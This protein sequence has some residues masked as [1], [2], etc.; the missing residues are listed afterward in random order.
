MAD[1]V[2]AALIGAGISL[3]ISGAMTGVA[4]LLR[5]Q[6]KTPN[7]SGTV[8]N[9]ISLPIT[10]EGTPIAYV[11]GTSKMSG[12]ITWPRSNETLVAHQVAVAGGVGGGK[13]DGGGGGSSTETQYE[14]SWAQSLCWGVVSRL[15]AIEVNDKRVWSGNIET[16]ESGFY[17][18]IVLSGF[19][20]NVR[21]YFGTGADA[22]RLIANQPPWYRIAY[23]V[24]S[25]LNVGTSPMVPRVDFWVSREPDSP[26]TETHRMWAKDDFYVANPV[27]VLA[28]LMT[29]PLFGGACDAGELDADSWNAAA[30]ACFTEGRGVC[31]TIDSQDSL[32]SIIEKLLAHVDGGLFRRDGKWVLKLVRNDY[33]PD[34]LT[35]IPESAIQSL[36]S[37]FWS[38]ESVPK[39]FEVEYSGRVNNF[40]STIFPMNS[41]SSLLSV[42]SGRRERISLP[43]VA[44]EATARIIAATRLQALSV[45]H[46]V[47]NV[48]V[49]RFGAIGLEWGDCVKLV[50][51]PA[52]LDGSKVY[53]ILDIEKPMGTTYAKLKLTEEVGEI[54]HPAP[55]T[56]PGTGGSSLVTS[57]PL[58]AQKAFELPY[59]LSKS[60]PTMTVLASRRQVHYGDLTLFG[61][62]DLQAGLDYTLTT[63]GKFVPT[64]TL[65]YAISGNGYPIDDIPVRVQAG[66][67]FAR[68]AQSGGVTREELFEMRRVLLV[69]DEL[70]AFQSVEPTA[71]PGVYLITGMLRGVHGTTQ[72]AHSVGASVFVLQT[73]QAPYAV[74]LRRDW[75][76]KGTVYLRAVPNSPTAPADPAQFAVE[77][78]PIDNRWFRPPAPYA[79]SVDANGYDPSFAANATVQITFLPCCRGSGFGWLDDTGV[80]GDGVT[81]DYFIV[82]VWKKNSTSPDYVW[83]VQSSSRVV[84]GALD[85]RITTPFN[86][87]QFGGSVPDWF[88]VKI[89][90]VSA[91]EERGVWQSLLPTV[92]RVIKTS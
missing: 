37:S 63:V 22:E 11:A 41:P 30:L 4:Y 25:A 83:S 1:P 76:S 2:S 48:E 90:S 8:T 67:D 64:A 73:G 36:E 13:G 34:D 82:Q 68:F 60:G 9:E 20:G 56:I 77:T 53:R 3:A 78:L 54:S 65:L 70:I 81:T 88:D 21:F 47:L 59:S 12:V 44:D 91:T 52:G 92:I 24:F 38:P 61:S 40:R 50:Y 23:A 35:V 26:L 75:A 29:N 43:W 16:P 80:F 71:T 55:P 5:S 51:P 46:E 15:L 57:G 84:G 17:D 19:S 31:V 69:D 27:H 58:P 66:L 18:G 6:P 10:T 85:G 28:E 39:S 62:T 87:S 74:E 89:Y 42:D 33:D 32:Q 79:L 72:A 49:M 14:V 86:T 45:A 7:I